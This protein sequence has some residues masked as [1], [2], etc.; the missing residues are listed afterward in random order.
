LLLGGQLVGI[1]QWL[2]FAAAAYP[3]VF[4][5]GIYTLRRVFMELYRVPF[6]EPFPFPDYLYIHYI[7]GDAIGNENHLSL[8]PGNSLSL[9]GHICNLKPFEDRPLL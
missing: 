8:E 5:E 2:P 1:W 3:E 6:H 4:T 7:A 9:G